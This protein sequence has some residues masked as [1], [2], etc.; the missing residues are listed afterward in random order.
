[1]GSGKDESNLEQE[2][3]DRILFK[4]PKDQAWKGEKAGLDPAQLLAFQ[5]DG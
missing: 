4:R 2:R 1:M 5:K 3:N